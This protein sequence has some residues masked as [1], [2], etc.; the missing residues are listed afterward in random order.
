MGLFTR[1]S[2]QSRRFRGICWKKPCPH[3]ISTCRDFPGHQHLISA[4]GSQIQIA[5]SIRVR[6]SLG[7]GSAASWDWRSWAVHVVAEVWWAADG[8]AIGTGICWRMDMAITAEKSMSG[9]WRLRDPCSGCR[10][11][12]G[13]PP[14]STR[15][16]FA[17]QSAPPPARVQRLPRRH[18]RRG[19]LQVARGRD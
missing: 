6:V 2:L 4:A 15:D 19:D 9:R 1:F 16:R 3:G 7:A 5:T 12:P 17:F 14:A 8:C 18:C 13:G 11:R 10:K